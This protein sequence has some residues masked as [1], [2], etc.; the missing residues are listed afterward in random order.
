MTGAAHKTVTFMV[1]REKESMAGGGDSGG[2]VG[3]D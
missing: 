1:T 2:R 3:W